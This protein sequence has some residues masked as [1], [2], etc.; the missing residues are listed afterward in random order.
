MKLFILF[1]FLF[2]SAVSHADGNLVGSWILVKSYC[3]DKKPLSGSSAIESQNII[4]NGMVRT[5]TENGEAQMA[6]RIPSLFSDYICSA[7]ATMEYTRNIS[8][9]LSI[10]MGNPDISVNGCWATAVAFGVLKWFRK[11]PAQIS[12]DIQ[13]TDDQ[14]LMYQPLVQG[15]TDFDC[16]D[17]IRV[18]EE[19]KRF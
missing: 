11:T 12:Y 2:V 5:F 1:S 7:E 10:S 19:Y 16:G 15:A 18:V 14:L 3:E 9:D 6:V 8:N 4:D 17:T 13:V